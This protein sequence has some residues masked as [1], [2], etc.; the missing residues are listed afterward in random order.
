[1][2][3]LRRAVAVTGLSALVA[4]G[5]VAVAQQPA[6]A[7][8]NV[9]VGG[10][11]AVDNTTCG[12]P[13][14]TP[15]PSTD[16][17]CATIAYA[18]VNRAAEG[19]TLNVRPGTYNMTAASVAVPAANSVN[20]L[21]ITKSMTIQKDPAPAFALGTVVL[22]G[23]PNAVNAG[24]ITMAT[25]SKTL[26]LANL[27]IQ[28]GFSTFGGALVLGNGQ[29]VTVNATNV[30]Y[31]NHVGIV[32]GAI[33]VGNG[34]TYNQTGGSFV[35]NQAGATT[36]GGLG[37]ALFV[38]GKVGPAGTPGKATLTNV[39]FTNNRAVGGPTNNTGDGGAIYNAGI[40]S[41]T[42]GTFAN[43]GAFPGTA[44]TLVGFG[45]AI[46]NGAFD[47]DD[48]PTLSLTNTT[49]NGG[50]PTT[51]PPNTPAFTK[52][53]TF[54]GAVA[55]LENLT[56]V[57]SAAD[58]VLTTDGLVVDGT[59]VT[60]SGGAIRNGGPLTMTGGELKNSTAFQGA[61]LY[62]GR[63]AGAGPTASLTGVAITGN[64]ASNVGGGLLVNVAGANL[65]GGSASSNTSVSGGGA[66][67]TAG[68][69][70]TTNGTNLQNNIVNP[71]AAT[72]FANG[73][74]IHN[75]G[76]TTVTGGQLS[77]NTVTGHATTAGTG[78]GGAIY[79]GAGSTLTVS[80]STLS[81]NTA[82]ASASQSTG[83]GGG[84]YSVGTALTVNQSTTISG[85]KA[86]GSTTK[87]TGGGGG[88]FSASL[89]TTIADTT[90]D[91]NTASTGAGSTAEATG[92][93]GGLYLFST[94]P[95]TTW[96]VNDSTFTGND[97]F[98]STGANSGIGGGILQ[99]GGTSTISGATVTGNTAD[100]NGGGFYNLLGTTMVDGGSFQGNLT[101]A[102]GGA[103]TSF[104][105][106]TITDATVGGTTANKAVSGAGVYV[107]A[108][109]A[110]LDGGSITANESSFSGGGLTNAGTTTVDGTAIDG[111][112]AAAGAGVHNVAGLT[113]TD[114]SVSTNKAVSAG[115]IWNQAGT[116]A[117]TDVTLNDNT[118]TATTA[119]TGLGGGILNGATATFT[120]STV[121]GNSAVASSANVTGLGGAAFNSGSLTFD[122][123]RVTD[124]AASS[125]VGGQTGWGGGVYNGSS[126]ANTNSTLVVDH[127]TLDANSATFG[128]AVLGFTEGA[129]SSN[130]TAIRRSTVSGNTG[131]GSILISTGGTASIVESTVANNGTTGTIAR[132]DNATIA[133]AGTIVTDSACAVGS[134]STG[135]FPDG[136]H[137]LA[138]PGTTGCFPA[139]NGNVFGDPLL[140]ALGANGGPTPTH[141]P[142]PSSPA[143]DKVPADQ[144]TSVS[145][146][147]TATTVE[148]CDT[149][150]TDQRGTVIP[151]G[152]LC[153]IGSVE[154][155]QEAP[156]TI[157]GPTEG[158]FTVGEEDDLGPYSAT[159]SPTP[160]FSA[161]GLPDGLVIESTGPGTAQITGT[162]E[163]GTGG[164]H[165]VVVK[166]ENEA[167]SATLD[168]TITVE[169]A[170]QVTG[171]VT[172]NLIET[173]DEPGPWAS[174]TS[175]GFPTP[176]LSAGSG[177]PTGVSFTAGPDGTGSID[178][179]P[180]LGTAGT[181]HVTITADNGVGVDGTLD[182]TINVVPLLTITTTSLPDA[183]YHTAYST[184]IAA[185]GGTQPYTFGLE[186]GSSLPAG[187]SLAAD[188]TLSGRPT[189]NPGVYSFT[190]QATDSSAETQTDTQALTL[191]IGKGVT[192]LTAG[193]VIIQQGPLG[194]NIGSVNATLRGGSGPVEPIPGQ[195]IVYKAGATNTVVCTGVTDA[196]GFNS[197]S[198]TVGNT[199]LVIL[200][201]GVTATYA[202]NTVWLPS[203]GSAG[204]L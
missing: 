76:T 183:A 64:T 123:T 58:A 7:A 93:G 191:T 10:T 107:A 28:D 167:G 99:F 72:N 164:E 59:T 128:S 185:I 119:N 127:S 114:A 152:A 90:F 188:G 186:A 73:G 101:D 169:E 142:G 204:L 12:G 70:L 36:N 100:G 136:G 25:P 125:T 53:A 24:M 174:Y 141:L 49:I 184:T 9:H 20:R 116:I 163:A 38:T 195:T 98:G 115:G 89:T 102:N 140:G 11:A 97:A 181:Y 145:D 62:H 158:T 151:Q 196:N 55:S 66:Y 77:G 147:V 149:G 112:K 153:D 193:P 197:C 54:G 126:A 65:S 192:T 106:T 82:N 61:G 50:L 121:S 155:E 48:A 79:S 13:G 74:A 143:L 124:N 85:N 2:R 122:R 35:N 108:G 171:P 104:G 22:D 6:S 111:N 69:T 120:T 33:D 187:L 95:G 44:G 148:L 110:T 3:A 160:T 19:D 1:M 15:A 178:G 52:N 34:N 91:D 182:V 27:T 105:A 8:P 162:P 23:G 103:I 135:S 176:T 45:G 118:A 154:R 199:L 130:K 144:A 172:L 202:G 26:A 113:L 16:H 67:V 133:F 30:I 17:P 180:A 18:Y 173:I 92:D 87:S 51:T 68:S 32:G 31:Q 75:L 56:G 117:A 57:A 71:V 175:S 4:T 168:V 137:N 139:G 40:A 129:T 37:G 134:G 88:I 46:W 190:V 170:A 83:F 189:A 156:L 81:A 200:N 5:L 39:S 203:S 201:G 63:F 161:T 84:I 14:T 157:D 21:S 179:A 109:N 150:A 177:F 42:G 159:G 194:V 96:A 165:L 29:N 47:A 198:M 94:V 138:G 41:V 166:A 132:G 78:L 60:S 131:G 86:V 146:A 80:A 43:N